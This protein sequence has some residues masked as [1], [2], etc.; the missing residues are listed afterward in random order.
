MKNPL[1]LSSYENLNNKVELT[2]WI[3]HDE[4]PE[5]LNELK[6][7]ILPSYTEGLPGIVQEG[8]ACGTVVLA[9][10]V[11]GIPDL[12]KDE[13]TGFIMED[14]TPECIA[15]NVIRALKHP[16]LERIVKNARKLIEDEYSYEVI[17]R[18]CG[19]SLDDLMKVKR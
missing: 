16:D 2:G 8:M 1:G 6:L 13:E 19:D 15:K 12:I 7:L 4:L 10:P 3:L 17:V 14:N 5:Y 18:K 11:G 9:T